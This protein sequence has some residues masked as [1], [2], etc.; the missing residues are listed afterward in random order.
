MRTLIIQYYID[1]NLYDIPQY[2]NLEPSPIEKYSLYAFEQYAKKYNIEFR[3][4]EQPKLRWKHP[5]W[6]R[7]DLWMDESWWDQYDQICYVDS[8]IIPLPWSGNIFKQFKDPD[9]FK[10]CHYM[11]F[12]NNTIQG[13]KE[14]VSNNALMSNIPGEQIKDKGFQPG[15]F[16][17]SKKSAETMRPYVKEFTLQPDNIDD[18]M[19]LNWA[20][21]VSNVVVEKMPE[22]YNRKNNGETI[23][24]KT[25]NFLHCAGGKKRKPTSRVF[26]M[27]KEIYP[28]VVINW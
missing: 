3:R 23:N 8:D 20:T 4:I 19:L 24:L 9:A 14:K 7:M 10:V 1:V 6:E 16:I 28:E 18:G 26:K 13:C 2:N 15:L 5:T 22:T 12:S 11:R 21:I 17:L 25:L 27:M